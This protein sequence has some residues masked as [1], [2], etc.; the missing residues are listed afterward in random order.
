MTIGVERRGLSV[1][2]PGPGTVNSQAVPAQG[3]SRGEMSAK[4]PLLPGRPPRDGRRLAFRSLLGAALLL[5]LIGAGHA[6]VWRSMA[7]QLQDGFTAW[8]EGRR[9]QGWR[10]EHA[11]PVRGGWPLSATLTLSQ[12]RLA[13]GGATLPGGMDWQAEALTLRLSLPRLDRLV[14]EMPGRHRLRLA[15]AEWPF[16]ADRLIAELPIERHVLPRE[17]ALEA[18]RLRVGT[19][20]GTIEAQRAWLTVETRTTAIEGEPAV[21]LH[22]E[23]EAVQLPAPAGTIPPLLASLGRTLQALRLDLALTGPVPPGRSPATRAEAWRDGGGTLELRGLELR[24]G[25]V[26]AASTATMTLDD[27]L[28]PMGAGTLQLSGADEALDAAAAAGLLTPRGAGT[29]RTVVR[30]LSRSPAEGGP[31]RL[32]VPLTLEDRTLTL[33]RIPL[34]RLAA[35][36]WPI[37]SG[38]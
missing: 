29:A 30:L 28:Q 6:L 3:I 17:A 24:W 1:L 27:A 33:A 21:S 37:P 26:S 23:A 25:P 16:A 14:V 32:D 34:I 15:Q 4:P 5:A 10:V 2:H 9:A 19:V 18:E 36:D 11:P 7:S 8:T 22:G 12:F 13:G 38:D 35:W 20:S 31:P